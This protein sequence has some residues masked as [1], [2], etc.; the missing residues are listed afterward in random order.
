V[1]PEDDAPVDG[2]EGVLSAAFERI[3]NGIRRFTSLSFALQFP[4]IA[5]V[6]LI[7]G[8]LGPLE[9]EHGNLAFSGG[10][11][12]FADTTLGELVL[13]AGVVAI[14]QGYRLARSRRVFDSG[15]IA[16]LG[17][18]VAVLTAIEMIRIHDSRASIGWGLYLTAAAAAA[19]LI[20]GLILLG[21][22]AEGLPPPD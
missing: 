11:Y 9:V 15:G 20:S 19:L 10:W 4:A 13:L 17:L 8:T 18:F 14:L 2:G 22:D 1:Q 5:A 12:A 16:A 21:G 3:R 6:A 7:V